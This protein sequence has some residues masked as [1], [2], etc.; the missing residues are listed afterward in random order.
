MKSNGN[1][2]RSAENVHCFTIN[3]YYVEVGWKGVPDK[4]AL[5]FFGAGLPPRWYKEEGCDHKKG[6][7]DVCDSEHPGGKVVKNESPNQTSHEGDF[8][9]DG[10]NGKKPKPVLPFG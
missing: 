10:L 2:L 8:L 7:Q 9:L 4:R 5:L 1:V 6:K 3:F